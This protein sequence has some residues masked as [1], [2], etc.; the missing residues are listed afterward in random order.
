[1][2]GVALLACW[3]LAAFAHLN[4]PPDYN[5]STRLSFS[6]L[7]LLLSV[8]SKI[9]PVYC[10]LLLLLLLF[11][12]P[13]LGY[14]TCRP[15]PVRES[16]LAVQNDT[17]PSS[18]GNLDSKNMRLPS[19]LASLACFRASVEAAL[20][21]IEFDL[22][23]PRNNVSY[24]PTPRL[25][26][27][28]AVKNSRLGQ[29]FSPS[30]F[31]QGQLPDRSFSTIAMFGGRR[32]GDSAS[33]ETSFIYTTLDVAGFGFM[34]EGS[35]PLRFFINWMTCAVGPN[36]GGD[37]DSDTASGQSSFAS[38]LFHTDEGGQAINLLSSN[39][40]VCHGQ[41]GF[42]LTVD[43]EIKTVVD[44]STAT[45]GVHQC[46]TVMHIDPPGSEVVSDPC[47][48]KVPTGLVEEISSALA[49]YRCENPAYCASLSS[50]TASGVQPSTTAAATHTRTAQPAATTTASDPSKNAAKRLAMAGSAGLAVTLSVLGLLLA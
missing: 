9:S 16:A 39:D 8:W 47:S 13:S 32:W 42:R 3:F 12:V 36:G 6:P 7:P 24:A 44:P 38:I 4:I 5:R 50:T 22:V 45:M 29:N 48:A 26:I 37:G 19:I 25:P 46:L 35:R 40:T 27:I 28:F 31:V 17:V 30:F 41:P 14:L 43:D 49:R 23:F 10:L 15:Q 33:N 18:L 2:S 21:T 11:L 1:M 20:T 34:E